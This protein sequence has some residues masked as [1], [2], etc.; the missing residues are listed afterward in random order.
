MAYL[1]ADEGLKPVIKPAILNSFAKGQNNRDFASSL[2]DNELALL[3]NAI[4]EDNGEVKKRGGQILVGNDVASTACLGLVK[5]GHSTQGNTLLALF[6]DT[7]RKFSGGV[8]VAVGAAY[9][10]NLPTFFVIAND[11]AFVLNGTD[12]IRYY[13]IATGVVTVFGAG[14][15]DPPLSKIGIW[16]KNRMFLVDEGNT[17]SIR[18]S[19]S[20]DPL[21]YPAAN[22]LSVNKK[23][24]QRIIAI[25]AFRND[26]IV[27]KEESVWALN[28]AGA[29]PLTD[30]VISAVDST[31]GT[32]SPRSVRQLGGDILFLDQYGQVRSLN[33]TQLDVLQT[34]ARPHS[35]TVRPTLD[36][37][38]KAQIAKVAAGVWKDDYLLAFS[39]GTSIYNDKVLVYNTRQ[40]SWV[41]YT[42]WNVSC[43]E[44]FGISDVDYLIAGEA[45]SASRIYRCY[46]G[47]SDNGTAIDFDL[48]TKGYDLEY[49]GEKLWEL[50]EITLG[51]TGGN[52]TVQAQ[53]DYNGWNA[54]GTLNMAGNAPTLPKTLPFTLGN[55]AVASAKYTLEDLGR[56]KI[57]QIR[58]RNSTTTDSVI[59]R[60]LYLFGRL[61]PYERN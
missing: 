28:M 56:G 45:S 8:W 12:R 10:A 22:E 3:R 51:V 38:N 49:I 40:K 18:Y 59:I 31:Y 1:I 50:A 26:L 30:W 21:V 39:S 53:I 52:L 9:T 4:I 46:S 37:L 34:G 24:G 60:N 33:R 11:L 13:N 20:G 29:D 41:E 61:L 58:L 17:S 19:N 35:D 44:R 57:M 43:W 16:I 54:L 48:Q 36:T 14:A 47:T 32:K 27:F 42:G 2:A 6:N 5:Y 7:L 25:I 23:D 55:E 15:S